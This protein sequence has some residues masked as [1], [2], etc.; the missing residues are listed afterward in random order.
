MKNHFKGKHFTKE[1]ILFC[2]RWYL[3]TSLSY[4]QVADLI[5]ERGFKMNKS[6]IWRWVQVYAP[7]LRKRLRKFVK[8]STTLF[9]TLM[10]L[11][12]K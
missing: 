8:M 3:Q 1:V 7:L 12:L 2:I 6:T 5:T 11:I 10:K 9:I 4:Q